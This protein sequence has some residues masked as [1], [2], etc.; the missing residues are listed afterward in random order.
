MSDSHRAR[1]LVLE[2]GW[3]STAYQILNPGMHYWFSKN[4]PAVAG[5]VMRAR[6]MVIA[7]APV[8]AEKMLPS[9]TRE[10]E[11]HARARG[12]G[13]CYVHV[14]HR[15]ADHFESSR[16]HSRIVLGAQPVWNPAEWPAI[17]RARPSLRA[18]LRRAQNKSVHVAIEHAGHL[19]D[20]LDFQRCLQEWLH[21]RPLPPMGFLVEPETFRGELAD[22]LLLVARRSGAP[23]GY[24]LASPIPQRNGF[25]VEQIL[26]LPN[27]P[28]GTVELLIDALMSHLADAGHPY[29]T[30]G[31][32]ALTHHA[33]PWM[34]NNPIWLRAIMA[35]AR[36]HGRHFYDFDGLEKFR[37]K[38][39]PA[40]WEPVFAIAAE[41]SFSLRSFYALLAAFS[42]MP[43]SL[44]AFQAI[45]RS[46]VKAS[47]RAAA[48][49][50]I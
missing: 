45:G 4:V 32:V 46:L 25:L 9:V 50:A 42:E 44:M 26:R 3:N 22:R 41:P 30:L 31:L 5:Y 43:L 2:Y 20:N 11:A 27:A 17:L 33:D 8:C 16:H 47:R 1:H 23:V 18:Q 7:G 34:K 28:N 14:S 48:A 49:L 19:H 12:E 36:R 21:S 13:L 10:L 29:L 24:L 38:L 40:H 37:N 39:S 35:A 15:L 6:T